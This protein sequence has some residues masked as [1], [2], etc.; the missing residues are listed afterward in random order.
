MSRPPRSGSCVRDLTQKGMKRMAIEFVSTRNNLS[1]GDTTPIIFSAKSE[2]V[3]SLPTKDAIP[4]SASLG[5]SDVV[6]QKAAERVNKVLSGSQM[7]FEYTL[8]KNTSF[9]GIKVIDS[10]TKEVV[11]E[12][13]SEQ[14]FE[15]MDKLPKVSGAIIDEKG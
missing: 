6:I 2:D 15:I 4:S 14:F 5:V 11:R 8:H 13:P 7:K 9:V 3:G 10:V 1:S 12:I